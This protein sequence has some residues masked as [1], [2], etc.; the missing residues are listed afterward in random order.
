MNALEIVKALRGRWHGTY[1]MACCPAHDDRKPSLSIA[2]GDD[3]RLLVCCHAG[4]NGRDVLAALRQRGLNE[5]PKKYDR[6]FPRRV[7]PDR[8][9]ERRIARAKRIWTEA[10]PITGTHAEIYLRE[11]GLRP[12]FPPTLRF[13][14]RLDYFGG[15]GAVPI[16]LPALVAAVTVWPSLSVEAVQVTYLDPRKPRKAQVSTPRKSHG[17]I[18]GAAIRLAKADRYLL[19]AEGLESCLSAML[20]TDLPGWATAGTSGLRSL[21][22]P[23]HVTEITIAADADDAGEQAA[24]TAAKRWTEEGRTV[25]IARP[26]TGQ[27]FNDALT[28]TVQCPM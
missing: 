21:I 25:R 2:D 11:R 8:Q 18:A 3:G 4:C 17:R 22:L 23:D 10:V 20:A 1:G 28:E 12:P 26:P 9:L 5:P 13:H 24:Q 15:G 19:L 16:I 7:E 27:D 6:P 14:S